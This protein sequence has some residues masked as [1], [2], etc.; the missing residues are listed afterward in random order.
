MF[1]YLFASIFLLFDMLRICHTA[2]CTAMNFDKTV[3]YLAVKIFDISTLC[4]NYLDLNVI[5]VSLFSLIL[6]SIF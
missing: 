6:L 5:Q 2:K 4:F 3:L 1:V